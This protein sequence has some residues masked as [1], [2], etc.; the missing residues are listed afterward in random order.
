MAA[1]KELSSGAP[2]YFEKSWS[3]LGEA[4][5]DLFKKKDWELSFLPNSYLNSDY[6]F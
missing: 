2:R 5:R 1:K 6:S 3:L 4:E